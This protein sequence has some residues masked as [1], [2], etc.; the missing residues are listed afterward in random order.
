[1]P[2]S[3]PTGG[4]IPNGAWSFSPGRPPTNRRPGSCSREPGTRWISS[5]LPRLS[6]NR[7]SGIRTP[8]TLSSDTVWRRTHRLGGYTCAAAGFLIVAAGFLPHPTRL[9]V[10]AA[11]FLAMTMIPIVYSYRV[12]R[13]LGEGR[14]RG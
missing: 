11:V 2:W 5:I 4:A 14:V 7:W 9:W 6:P 13:E 12:W 3:R 1:M 8:W 10:S